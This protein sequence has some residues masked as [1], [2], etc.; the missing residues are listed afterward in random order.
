DGEDGMG[1]RARMA[2]T[3]T[4]VHGSLV[5]WLAGVI[6]T[7]ADLIAGVRLRLATRREAVYNT[8]VHPQRPV[9]L[10]YRSSGLALFPSTQEDWLPRA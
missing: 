10:P 8:P 4:P 9:S 2:G 5:V 7:K 1:G 3:Y 6:F